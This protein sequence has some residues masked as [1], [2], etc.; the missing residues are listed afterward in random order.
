MSNYENH[1]DQ[2]KKLIVKSKDEELSEENICF[3]QINA[4]REITKISSKEFI[5]WRDSKSYLR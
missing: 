2:S 1:K 4:I 3:P 5:L